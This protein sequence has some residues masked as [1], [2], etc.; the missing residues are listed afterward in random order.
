MEKE[1][2][3]CT[4]ASNIDPPSSGT[5]DLQRQLK[6]RHV[7]M[8][9]VTF[10]RTSGTGLF[11]GTGTALSHGGPASL[12]I[13]YAFT[14]ILAWA[15][16][17]SLGEMICHLPVAGGHTSLAFRFFSPSMGFTLGWAYWYTWSLTAEL[18]ASAILI[19]FWTTSINPA[20][21]MIIFL[22]GVSL[23]NLGGARLYGEMEFWFCSIKIVTIVGVVI[24]GIILDLGGV[25]GERIGFRYWRDP[26][27]IEIIF[28]QYAGVPG[29]AGRFCGFFSVF[30]TA[31]FSYIGIEFS[32]MAAAEAKNPR[33]NMPKAIRRVFG[34]V[35]LFVGSSLEVGTLALLVPSNEPRLKLA[36]A[37]GAKSPFV[38]A[39][40]NAGI[41]GLPSVI[42][43]SL[44][45]SALSSGSS[46]LYV[47][48]RTLYGLS[49]SGNAPRFLSKLTSNGLPI[50]CYFVGIAMGSLSLMSAGEGKAGRVFGF[51]VSMTSVSGLLT[52]ASIFATYIRFHGG[53]AVQ[54]YDKSQ[55]PYRSPLGPK[56]AWGG[57]LC[58]VVIIITNGF[59]V[60]LKGSWDFETFFTCYFPVV[61]YILTFIAHSWWTGSK[62]VAKGSMDFGKSY[63]ASSLPI[64][65][66]EPIPKNLLEKIWQ[67]LM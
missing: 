23:I 8:I 55:L 30:I 54:R 5:N 33:R 24:L 6:N 56:A 18:A 22:I 9:S 16:M 63:A 12:V 28:H 44:L 37:T 57:L 19:R 50:Y 39:V 38:I 1:L 4:S 14:G 65:E 62:L 61:A 51:L 52:W 11:I 49:I 41:R 15:L 45:T 35:L 46:I 25:T 29:A 59:G 58:C 2:N 3:N 13:G 47:C 64:E 40:Q 20:L 32:A 27:H 26:G 43:A 36:V 42:N 10:P 67:F 60:F 7:A 53:M 66:D 17:C 48:T 31:A 34:R 21:W